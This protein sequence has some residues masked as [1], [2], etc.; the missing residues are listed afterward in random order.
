[1]RSTLEILSVKNRKT[2]CASYPNQ[3][4]GLDPS[5]TTV[6]KISVLFLGAG[7]PS[8][9]CS[10]YQGWGQ[11]NWGKWGFRGANGAAKIF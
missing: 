3:P 11:K 9:G 10:I 5:T 4:K 2:T 7:D 8:R 6:A 1:M